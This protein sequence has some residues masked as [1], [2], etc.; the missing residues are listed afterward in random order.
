MPYY[1]IVRKEILSREEVE[2]MVEVLADEQD[3]CL[4]CMLYLYGM[5]PIE[6]YNV[7]RNSFTLDTKRNKLWLK[8]HTAKKRLKPHKTLVIDTRREI[9]ASFDDPFTYIIWNY[10]KKQELETPLFQY[11]GTHKS[12]NKGIDRIL[13]ASNPNVCAYLFR[14]TRNTIHDQLGWGESQHVGWNG[15]SDT[16]P[17][18][19]YSRP[20]K[21]LFDTAKDE[22]IP[23]PKTSSSHQEK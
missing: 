12:H 23:S 20:G 22:S 19:N 7:S 1:R 15:W 3:K 9:Y 8:I 16:R 10:V 21:E 18:K 2:K 6:L 5:R 4:V 14:Y 11:G 17:L 13:K